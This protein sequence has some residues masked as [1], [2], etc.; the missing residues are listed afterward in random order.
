MPDRPPYAIIWEQLIGGKVIIF[1][2]AGASVSG[3]DENA[4]WDEND[5]D[6]KFL[7]LGRELANSLASAA[8]LSLDVPH[9]FRDLVLEEDGR[10]GW[11]Q[12]ER[13]YFLKI[14]YLF[15]M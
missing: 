14:Q 12:T 11:T 4:K 1:L 6:P 3:R 8:G 5:P 13:Q 9:D 2:G 10:E 15:Q 7:P